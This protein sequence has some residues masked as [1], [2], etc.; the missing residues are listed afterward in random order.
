MKKL[1]TFLCVALL[2]SI[3]IKSKAQQL[4]IPVS[5]SIKYNRSTQWPSLSFEPALSG[6]VAGVR[7][8]GKSGQTGSAYDIIIRNTMSVLHTSNRVLYVVD[9]IAVNSG[10]IGRNNISNNYLNWLAPSDIESIVILKDAAAT[11]IYG[12]AAAYGAVVITTKQGHGKKINVRFNTNIGFSPTFAHKNFETVSAEMNRELMYEHHYNSYTLAQFRP[13]YAQ[14]YAQGRVNAYIPNTDQLTDWENLIYRTPVYQNYDLSIYGDINGKTKYH[15]SGAYT[16]DPGRV[17]VNDADRYSVRFNFAQKILKIFEW[18]S[19][20]SYSKTSKSGMSDIADLE[21]LFYLE[22]RYLLNQW[23]AYNPDGSLYDKELAQYHG[24]YNPLYTNQFRENNA[25]SGH[26]NVNE[27]LK[28]TLFDQLTIETRFGYE[29]LE[30]DESS[31]YSLQ[32]PSEELCGWNYSADSKW[33]RISSYNYIG[34]NREIAGKHKL[35]VKGGFEFEKQTFNQNIYDE[36]CD[37]SGEQLG[38]I[39]QRKDSKSYKYSALFLMGYEYNDR[40]SVLMSFRNESLKNMAKNRICAISG[41]WN[42]GN[43]EFIKQASWISALNL[44]VAHSRNFADWEQE[45]E[46]SNHSD[47]YNKTDIGINGVLLNSRLRIDANYFI[48]NFTTPIVMLN[49]DSQTGAS[50]LESTPVTT[51]HKGVELSVAADIVS[52]K[53]W[54]WAIGVNLTTANSKLD[55]DNPTKELDIIFAPEKVNFLPQNGKSP[56]SMFGYEFAGI[57]PESGFQMWYM[58][59]GDAANAAY[60]KNVNGRPVT[61]SLTHAGKTIIGCTDPKVYG[62][63]YSALSWKNLSFDLN[64]T[65]SFGGDIFDSRKYGNSET[66]KYSTDILDRW[67]KPGDITDTPILTTN[68]YQKGY[69]NQYVYKNNYV[70]LKSLNIA[71]TLPSTITQKLK[72]E[73]LKLSFSATNLLT[74]SR[75]KDFDPELASAYGNIGWNMPMSRTYMLGLS[76][77]F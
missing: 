17:S 49:L 46:F 59:K 6:K 71:Y 13:E 36:R 42:I 31:A 9:G 14:E 70:R 21:N 51:S 8:V 5:D 18:N 67:Q 19:N 73:E 61:K 53:D 33:S 54:N 63:F 1:I 77:T 35:M 28:A 74:L 7:I 47:N 60:F 4:E 12:E 62:G 23:P 15:L 26:I 10:D 3:S 40:Y 39:E 68:I 56:N 76:M 29:N 27:S 32:H 69:S 37:A 75:N 20:I 11:A 52:N 44:K 16:K 50:K 72:M 55:V 65:Y 24:I 66:P 48:M 22:R 2:V 58:E 25:N 30:H 34:W 64:F 38:L 41:V 57:D 43:E 45:Y